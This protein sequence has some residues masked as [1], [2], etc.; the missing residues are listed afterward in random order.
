MSATGVPI[1]EPDGWVA[2]Y[3]ASDIKRLNAYFDWAAER[4][5]EIDMERIRLRCEIA[6]ANRQGQFRKDV[7]VGVPIQG[8]ARRDVE[9]ITLKE[10]EHRHISEICRLCASQN[11]AAMI[12]GL[13]KSAMSRRLRS[14]GIKMTDGRAAAGD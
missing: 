6:A 10:L 7:C 5:C 12:L 2:D 4:D 13:D 9:F 3:T 11:E 1:I 14:L 8:A